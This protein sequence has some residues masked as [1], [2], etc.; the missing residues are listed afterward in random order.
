MKNRDCQ[1]KASFFFFFLLNFLDLP[2]PPP[3]LATSKVYPEKK[4][5]VS[6][7]FCFVLLC[8]HLIT[9]TWTKLLHSTED[10]LHSTVQYTL[11]TQF[12]VHFWLF[13][14][15]F[16]LY[17]VH[18]SLKSTHYELCRVHCIQLIPNMSPA[19]TNLQYI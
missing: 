10:R 15:L 16:K 14:V 2:K 13:T 3:F 5:I 18:W 8:C 17:S 12:C 11:C 19:S 1:H 4:L 6:L 7:Y 9:L